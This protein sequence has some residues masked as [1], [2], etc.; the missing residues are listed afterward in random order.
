[1]GWGVKGSSAKIM[2]RKKKRKEKVPI[3]KGFLKA[4]NLLC[5]L[6]SQESYVKV[7]QI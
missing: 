5:Q 1:M 6:K 4:H 3:Q 2:K 7:K